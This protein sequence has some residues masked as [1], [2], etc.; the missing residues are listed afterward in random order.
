M[1]LGFFFNGGQDGGTDAGASGCKPQLRCGYYIAIQLIA[2][3]E[4]TRKQAGQCQPPREQFTP[5]R[6][7]LSCICVRM[8]RTLVTRQD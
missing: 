4:D 2:G 1:D 5:V 7:A 3:A 8:L 6:L